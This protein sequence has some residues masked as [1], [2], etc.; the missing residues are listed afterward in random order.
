MKIRG[1]GDGRYRADAGLVHG[2]RTQKVFSTKKDA[3]LWL[4]QQE[5]IKR[6]DRIGIRH[7][8]A[9]REQWAAAAFELLEKNG[10]DDGEI[11][12]AVKR[13]CSIAAPAR[14]TPL[15]TALE[16]FERD[17]ILANRSPIYIKQFG[18]Q[19]RRFYRA[20]EGMSLHEITGDHIREWLEVNC[21]TAANRA[22][23]RRELRVFFSWCQKQKLIAD[24]P[25]DKVPR[26]TVERGRPET[27][28]L[29]QVRSALKHLSDT[30]R[31]LFLVGVFAGLRPSE[32]EALRWEDVKLSRSFLTVVRTNTRDNRN[33]ALSANLVAW[34]KPLERDS[35]KVFEGHG[36]RWR[37]RVQKAIALSYA[38][39]VEPEPLKE[40]PQDVLRHTYGSYHLEKHHNAT[41]TAHEMGH[42]GNPRTLFNH[43]RDLVEPE[44]ASAFWDIMPG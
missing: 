3:E 24:N 1:F 41:E 36:R 29:N 16:S 35:G 30:D 18:R 33:V 27:L 13:Y 42:K 21:T 11:L 23:R 7:I 22:N 5:K 39:D 12:E 17:L 37:D 9:G 38:D 34:L 40:W 19:A 20:F 2:N 44:A 28:T 4:K 32:A 31:A 8:S 15:K 43:Y 14:R 25:A 26:I 10:L 6:D